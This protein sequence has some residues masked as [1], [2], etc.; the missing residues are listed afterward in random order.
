RG[1]RPAGQ[2]R[3]GGAMTP[4]RREQRTESREQRVRVAFTLPELLVVIAIGILLLAIAVPAFTSV[5]YSSRR[6]GAAGAVQTALAAARDVAVENGPG[7]DAAA[8]FF[9]DSGG[10]LRIMVAVWAGEMTDVNGRGEPVQREVFVRS[11][12]VE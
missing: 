10:R 6:S 3:G 4:E 1:D 7:R 2:H 8:V 5:L 11:G 9:A 12:R